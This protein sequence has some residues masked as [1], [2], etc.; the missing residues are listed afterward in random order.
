MSPDTVFDALA[1]LSRRRILVLLLKHGE[2]CVCDLFGVLNLAQPKVSRHLAI[3]RESEILVTRKQG[4]WVYYRLN[5]EMP[6]WAVQALQALADGAAR[7]EP[8]LQD[9]IQFSQCCN[10]AAGCVVALY[11]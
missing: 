6:L 11:K 1:D 2:L 9:Q 4:T 8:Y 7:S 3:L 5:P 10:S